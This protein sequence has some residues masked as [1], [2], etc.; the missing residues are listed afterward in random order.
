MSEPRYGVPA[1]TAWIFGIPLRPSSVATSLGIGTSVPPPPRGVE[2][3]TP[4]NLTTAGILATWVWARMKG[5]ERRWR[6]EEPGHL[7]V[8]ISERAGASVEYARNQRCVVPLSRV[9][10]LDH[11]LDQHQRLGRREG[12]VPRSVHEDLAQQV[13]LAGCCDHVG[14]RGLVLRDDQAIARRMHRQHGHGEL[15][16]EGDVAVEVGER[17]RVGG[18]PRTAVQ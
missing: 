16:V 11:L 17:I 13:L 15:T 3:S 14:V 1:I 12:A 2:V 10:P 5:R 4:S 7:V 18:D 9:E 8:G 6:D